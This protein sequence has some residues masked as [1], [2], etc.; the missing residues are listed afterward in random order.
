MVNGV[1]NQSCHGM[2]QLVLA[3]NSV[4]RI[5]TVHPLLMAHAQLAKYTSTQPAARPPH[6]QPSRPYHHD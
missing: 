2:G 4:I 6:T 1:S 5:N 3:Q